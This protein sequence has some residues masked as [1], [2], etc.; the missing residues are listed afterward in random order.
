MSSPRRT[1]FFLI[2]ATIL[3]STI[4]FGV[5]I[6]VL[7]L[8]AQQFQ[9][10]NF[11]NGLL[12]GIFSLMVVIGSPLWGRLSDRVG[13]RPVLLISILG[14]ALGYFIMGHG[15]SLAMLFVGRIID[16]ASGGNVSCAQAY[17]ADITKPE[18]RS[19]AMGM[20]GAAFGLGFV[21][22]PALGGYLAGIDPSAPFYA[23]GVLCLLNALFVYTSLPESL[24]P[25]KRGQ[26]REKQPLSTVLAHADAPLY[27]S[28][29][30]CYL[31][32]LI[33]FAIMTQ[34]F[35]LFANHR[36]G[37]NERQVGHVMAVIGL[38]GVLMQGVVV[39]RLLPILGE[40]KM[41]RTGF[42]CLLFAFSLFPLV[43]HDWR[44]YALS[45]FVAM[46]NAL[47]QPT[48][49]GI[50]SQSVSARWQGSAMG[51]MQSAGSMGRFLGATVGGWL[52]TFDEGLPHY[53]RTPFWVAAA[54]MVF[55]LAIGIRLRQ[56]VMR[57]VSVSTV[58]P[59]A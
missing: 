18:E 31:V 10:S 16:G 58:P 51:F 15:H 42:V 44:L 34:V 49:N 26:H 35:S 24:G 25:E 23:V 17:I 21:I 3:L 53:G 27:L 45:C 19:R 28:T 13:R 2:F 40:V 38:V 1:Q 14:S 37:M 12:T 39:R 41:A 54:L 55:T 43:G 22:G 5:C 47:V 57:E 29:A 59:V 4:G 56:P 52:L 11:E 50:A 9:A 8:Y 33:A 7:P 46:G 6:P 36:F 48:L 20:I 32:N 30:S